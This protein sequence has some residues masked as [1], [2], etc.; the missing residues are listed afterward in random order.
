MNRS[1]ALRL[2]AV[3]SAAL[4]ALSLQSPASAGEADALLLAES[5]ELQFTTPT[6]SVIVP[7]LDD[8]GPTTCTY[9]L[10]G[11]GRISRASGSS[12]MSER[13][14]V[15]GT[16]NCARTLTAALTITDSSVGA[17]TGRVAC[18]G[19]GFRSATCSA[20]QT[21]A[22]FTSGILTRPAST[23]V[24]RYQLFAGSQER[25]CF[26]Y[27]VTVVGATEAAQGAGPCGAS[28]V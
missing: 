11:S 25:I 26:E 7:E 2:V 27:K 1:L 10:T 16:T 12:V 9:D 17:P 19:S 20:S 14:S 5:A 15:K 4:S 18:I 13:G 3:G 21:V 28:T 23:V 24:F 22:Y 8:D 6:I